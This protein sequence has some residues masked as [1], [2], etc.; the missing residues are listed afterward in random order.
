MD[1]IGKLI[2]VLPEQRGEGARGAWV[3]GGFVIETEEQFPRKIAFSLWGED[4]VM[5]IKNIALNTS[6]KV[7]FTIESREYNERWYTDCRCNNVEVFTSA[8]PKTPYAQNP[9][10]YQNTG[11]PYNSAM[12]PQQPTAPQPQSVPTP[13]DYQQ[14]SGQL[15]G[16]IEQIQPEA[17]QEDVNPF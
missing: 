9:Q 15:G 12:P 10:G 2:Q 5:A 14:Q 4:K 16:T 8:M 7:V 17:P 3:R 13:P 1:V 11:M 6:I